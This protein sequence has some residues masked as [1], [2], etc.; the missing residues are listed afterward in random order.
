M[1]SSLKLQKNLHTLMEQMMVERISAK[2]SGNYIRIY[3]YGE[4]LIPKE[5]I[6][7]V[8]NEITEQ[9]FKGKDVIVKIYE[10]YTL[11]KQYNLQ[12]LFDE[13]F[14]SILWEFQNYNHIHHILLKRADIEFLSDSKMRLVVEDTELNKGVVQEVVRILDKIIYVSSYI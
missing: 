5:K 1:F 6:V 14:E 11:S 10:R 12:N 9:L 13:Y 7:Q 3:V 2:K 4:Y 8:E